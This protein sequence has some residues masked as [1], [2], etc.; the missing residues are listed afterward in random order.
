MSLKITFPDDIEE[1]A[2][3]LDGIS[4]ATAQAAQNGAESLEAFRRGVQVAIAAMVKATGGQPGQPIGHPMEPIKPIH[5]LHRFNRMTNPCPLK[6]IYA[7]QSNGYYC[8]FYQG[9]CPMIENPAY[10]YL[11]CPGWHSYEAERL[12]HVCYG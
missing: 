1:L 5:Q 7:A 10:D 12:Q 6:G 2:A 3:A 8:R 4:E 11:S 9:Y